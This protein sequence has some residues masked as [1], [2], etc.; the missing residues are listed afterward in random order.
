MALGT[1]RV[2]VWE[3][4]PTMN[5][6]GFHSTGL[7]PTLGLVLLLSACAA[8]VNW[9]YPRTPSTAIAPSPNTT[10]GALFQEAADQHPGLSGFSVVREGERAF[11]ARLAMA[12]LAE[13]TL[14]AQY[15]IW[16]GDITGQILADRLL[17]AADRGVRVRILIDDHYQTEARDF[18]LAALDAHPNI[19]VRFFNPVTNRVRRTMGFLRE[20]SRVNHRM[21]NKLIAVDNAVGI[22]GGRNVGDIYFGVK[23]DH[24]YRDLDVLTA[25]PIVSDLS[26]AFDLFWN[27]EW[28]I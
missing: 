25:G 22:V 17:R 7:V 18:Q 5:A 26:A 16:D 10:L 24:N 12:D 2:R 8:T 4:M 23:A 9:D 13:K 11:M 20:F 27:S 1:A 19:E 6:R 14:D 21:H 28:A 15:Y 3:I